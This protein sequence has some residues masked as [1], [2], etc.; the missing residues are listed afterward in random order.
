MT[1]MPREDEAHE[2][3]AALASVRITEPDAEI[4]AIVESALVQ[5]P[6]PAD[7]YP[8]SSTAAG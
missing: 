8:E 7:W 1:G 3:R 6:T 4:L 5:F 2:L